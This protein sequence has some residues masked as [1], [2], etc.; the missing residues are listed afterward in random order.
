M[1]PCSQCTQPVRI[2]QRGILCDRC[3]LWT[4]AKCCGV[5]NEDYLAISE[6]Q[7]EW[8]CPQCQLLELPSGN[9]DSVMNP[10]IVTP[11]NILT[12][13][14]IT[15]I[16]TSTMLE[17]L[18]TN[19][20]SEMVDN[21]YYVFCRD[22]NRHGGGVML[23][24]RNTICATRMTYLQDDCELLWIE[25]LHKKGKTLLGVFYNPTASGT[26]YLCRLR[27]SLA[28]IVDSCPIVFCDDFNTPNVNWDS[29]V[30]TVSSTKASLLCDIALGSSLCQLVP[31]AIVY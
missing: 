12:H 2:N 9:C 27:S 13:P 31:E 26:D 24:V 11:L 6:D 30:P 15:S 20:Y 21:S 5:S 23:L 14:S 4:N 18:W 19:C 3:D 8:L 22:C 17:A 29:S 25:I 7:F 28:L 10:S 1:Y 16:A